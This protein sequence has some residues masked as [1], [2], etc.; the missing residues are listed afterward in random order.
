MDEAE[1]EFEEKMVAVEAD[2]QIFQVRPGEYCW[3]RHS[4]DFEASCI[5]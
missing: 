1:D 3:P 2:A 4:M 5:E